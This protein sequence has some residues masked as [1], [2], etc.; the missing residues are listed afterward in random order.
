MNRTLEPIRKPCTDARRQSAVATKHRTFL[1]LLIFCS[2]PALS[3]RRFSDRLLVPARICLAFGFLLGA[4]EARAEPAVTV[5]VQEPWSN[6][7]AEKEAVFHAVLTAREPFDGRVVWQFSAD[8][9]T[10]A[11]GERA[12]KAGPAMPATVEVRLSVPPVKPGVI[13]QTTLS[14]GA[15]PTGIDKETA[16]LGRTLWVFPEDPFAG[17]AEWLK[18]LN[19]QLFDPSGATAKLFTKAGVPFAEAHNVEALTGGQDSLLVV[20]EGVS[21]KEYRGLAESLIKAAAAGRPVLCLAPESGEM[22]LPVSG[23]PAGPQPA[24]LAFGRQDLIRQLDKRLDE[25][26]WQGAGKA[27]ASGLKLRGDRGPVVA[28]VVKDAAGWPWMELGFDKGSGKLVVCGF[29]IVG[30]WAES[31]TPR[32]LLIK[33][34]EQVSGNKVKE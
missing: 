31:P 10:I 15:V 32:F 2:R 4:I 28:E 29:G 16:A 6:V 24:S 1:D 11:R 34:L 18:K 25:G 33:V 19:I 21:F 12:V 30:S 17:R 13:M 23:E 8:G 26:G 7:F 5:M 9:H 22:L 3:G 14:V 20:G 27:V